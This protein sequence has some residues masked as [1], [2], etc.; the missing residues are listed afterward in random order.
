MK[1]WLIFQIFLIWQHFSILFFFNE[2]LFILQVSN[3]DTKI[4]GA[5][6]ESSLKIDKNLMEPKLPPVPYGLQDPQGRHI[7]EVLSI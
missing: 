2:F 3:F 4:K 7:K 1:L 6:I 5:S